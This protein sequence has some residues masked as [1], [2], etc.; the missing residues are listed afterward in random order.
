MYNDAKNAIWSLSVVIS[1]QK[2][3]KFKFS[4]KNFF[5]YIPDLKHHVYHFTSCTSL[6]SFTLATGRAK[7]LVHHHTRSDKQLLDTLNSRRIFTLWKKNH[8]FCPK[9][10]FFGKIPVT[11]WVLDKVATS[12]LNITDSRYGYSFIDWRKN[13]SSIFGY[14][15]SL[16]VS[17]LCKFAWKFSYSN[18]FGSNATFWH[19]RPVSPHHSSPCRI[20]STGET[21][22]TREMSQ[23][24]YGFWMP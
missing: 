10:K 17:K 8:V 6:A 15:S 16:A 12:C 22:N 9:T 20:W 1:M 3:E 18:F 23:V 11:S 19:R 14:C 4:N 13:N 21:W 5:V 2:L 24:G 7:K